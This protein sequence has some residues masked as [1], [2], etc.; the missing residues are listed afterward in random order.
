M[1]CSADL[2]Y[3]DLI[4]K[5]TEISD[6]QGR[7][8]PV[9]KLSKEKS[10]LPGRKQVY[11]IYEKEKFKRDKERLR[12]LKQEYDNH[13]IGYIISVKAKDRNVIL[14]R[15]FIRE[16]ARVAEELNRLLITDR[17]AF[18]RRYRLF[19]MLIR[20]L[21]SLNELVKEETEE[22]MKRNSSN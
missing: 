4:Y 8:L 13:S 19:E 12:E 16:I 15:E 2:P 7:F 21:E 1:G 6:S 18:R 14:I 17:N 22:L 20:H 5:L 3:T 9:M 11:R 10:T